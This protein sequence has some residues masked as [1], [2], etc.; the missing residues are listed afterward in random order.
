MNSNDSQ[1]VHAAYSAALHGLYAITD[2]KLLPGETL[3]SGVALA[4]A[5]GAKVIQYRNK[6]ATVARQQEE[7]TALR[8][9]CHQ[10][11]VIFLVNDDVQLCLKS[12]ADGVHL[13]QQ[14][15]K[16]ADARHRLG[17]EAIIGVTCHDSG[18]MVSTAERAG[19][20]YVALG[21]FFPSQTKP[22]APAASIAILKQIRQ[23]TSLPIVAIG[24][25]TENNGRQLISA[26]AD[27]LAVIHGVFGQKNIRQHASAL[28]DL[29]GQANEPKDTTLHT[30]SR[31]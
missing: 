11:N 19:A 12:G 8:K 5:G 28:H 22:E 26:G 9:L 16:L 3:L 21:R 15:G 1:N 4:I 17:S 6:T 7:A 10:H 27:M 31:D 20:D 30:T 18:T 29:F 23:Q 25:I 14:D 2:P 13:G 24:G